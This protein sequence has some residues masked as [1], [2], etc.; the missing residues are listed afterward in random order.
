MLF[1]KISPAQKQQTVD[2]DK[3]TLLISL[4]VPQY[5][6]LINFFTKI[7]SVAI[8]HVS[9]E[10]CITV[11]SITAICITYMYDLY[12]HSCIAYK[13]YQYPIYM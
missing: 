13:K 6:Q 3:G 2:I 11:S 10:T 5:E 9:H 4:K 1:T 12:H 8:T 7:F